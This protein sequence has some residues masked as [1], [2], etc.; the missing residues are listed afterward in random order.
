M[1][2]P[3][4][5]KTRPRRGGLF[6]RTRRFFGR[7]KRSPR[8]TLA[9][10]LAKNSHFDADER[11]IL[12]NVLSLAARRVED[13]MVPRADIVALEEKTPK[14]RALAAFLKAGHSRLPV[15]RKRLDEPLGI[16]HVK[17][18]LGEENGVKR[19]G[20]GTTLQ[21]DHRSD[22]REVSLLRRVMRPPLF[23]PPSMA[24]LTL[25]RKMQ[26]ARLHLALVIDE[27]GGTCGLVSIEDL[28]EEIVGEIEDEHDSG[29][30][31]TLK[32]RAG[33]VIEADARFRIDEL[34]RRLDLS[35]RA[36]SADEDVSTLGGL[37]FTHA[38]R[39]PKKGD[40]VR[41]PS[42]WRLEVQDADPR[43][44]KRVR[45]HPSRGRAERDSRPKP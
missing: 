15:Y 39:L 1:P 19:P 2:S 41:H 44:V 31:L 17:D 33:G 14:E 16:V 40:I 34:E 26:A 43:R 30:A 12:K 42:G 24:V 7:R 25:L 11:R 3:S 22:N 8:E 23:V 6:A 35:L 5:P 18:L 21:E 36:G 28:V 45:L 38:G 10:W 9:R 20:S 4:D 27:H 13:V 29:E 37:L 32:R